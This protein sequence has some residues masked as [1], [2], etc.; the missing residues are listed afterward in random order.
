VVW[1]IVAIIVLAIIVGAVMWYQR[2]RRTDQLQEQFGPEYER[3]VHQYGDSSKAEDVLVERRQRVQNAN[4]HPLTPDQQQSFGDRWRDVQA[5]FVDDPSAAIGD[6]DSLVQEVMQARGYPTGNMFEQNADTI[7]VDYP[8]V[9][10]NY[11]KA[12][13]IAQRNED[14]NAS[15]EDLRQALIYY[16]SLFDELLQTSNQPAE[17]Q[18]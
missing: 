3:T 16:R 13:A 10:D 7:S 5:E 18:S 15:T 14:G 8:D 1:I 17:A 2:K 6:A 9:V 11:R 4:I 12:H